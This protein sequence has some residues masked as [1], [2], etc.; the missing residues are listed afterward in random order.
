MTL[1]DLHGLVPEPPD[2][3]LDWPALD[4][5]IR[6]RRRLHQATGTAAVAL[7]VAG[8]V[9]AA[10]SANQH[11][12]TPR[13]LSPVSHEDGRIVFG[14]DSTQVTRTNLFAD[15]SLYSV[16]PGGRGSLRLTH[17]ADGIGGAVAAPDGRRIAYTQ[18]T[19]GLGPA[20]HPTHVN[21]EYVRIVD[22]DGSDDHL[23]YDCPN[24]AC[25][26]LVWS[27]D[28]ARL[29]I[30]ASHVMQPD[31]HVVRLCVGHCAPGSSTDEASWSP[32]S[33]KLAFQYWVDVPLH[34]GR[35]GPAGTSTV[36]AVGVM[37]ADGSDPQLL[38]DRSCT[39]KQV[40]SCFGDANPIW[41]PDGRLIAFNRSI[42]TAL[43]PNSSLGGPLM[44]GP[45]RIEVMRPDGS[46][47]HQIEQC[48]VYCA[49]REM[50]WSPTSQRLAFVTDDE[51]GLWGR[52]PWALHTVDARTGKTLG[53]P[54][55]FITEEL[56]PEYVW[57]PSGTTIA[58][59]GR[60]GNG[61]RHPGI[62]L[63][64]VTPDRI[65]PPRLL[66][67]KGVLPVAWLARD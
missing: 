20:G 15:T 19:Y 5:R 67:A 4:G 14:E 6:R 31:G 46:G 7:V 16:T 49:I 28:S 3:L 53:V 65:G 61:S 26:D 39:A 29:L 21:G 42:L 51:R 34:N 1:L 12:T 54:L 66:S 56:T 8:V 55:A 35:S 62:Y 52:P 40:T 13:P 37:N 60:P 32:N 57:A 18:D 64:R 33:R 58:I 63:M 2:D 41:S 44:F 27:P 59:G 45:S 24:S 48:G 50:A 30:G 23:V 17:Q 25:G 36:S 43:I 38:T 11:A 47:L 9:A 22:A 10:V